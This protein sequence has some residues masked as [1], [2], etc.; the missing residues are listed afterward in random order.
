METECSCSECKG[1]KKQPVYELPQSTKRN[2][3]I[4]EIS[5][6]IFTLF[7]IWSL[8]YAWYNHNPPAYIANI[9][10]S[11]P[12]QEDYHYGSRQ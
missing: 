6:I 1:C 5:L 4:L 7:L 8:G 2:K 10:Q 9:P 3:L 11:T 12:S